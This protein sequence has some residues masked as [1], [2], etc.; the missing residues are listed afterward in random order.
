M[1]TTELFL[2]TIDSDRTGSD[3]CRHQAEA[4]KAA[5][6]LCDQVSDGIWTVEQAE[7]FLLAD[8]L[9]EYVETLIDD[10][11][12]LADGKRT[13]TGTCVAM[14]LVRCAF[15]DIDFREVADHYLTKLAE[16][17]KAVTA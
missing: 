9:K 13:E 12:A 3:F 8:S 17:G 14:T 4:S 1:T 7:R 5:A 15:E 16:N 11:Q 10:V 2:I 6:P